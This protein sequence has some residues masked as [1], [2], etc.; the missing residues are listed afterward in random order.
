[1]KIKDSEESNKKIKIKKIKNNEE[2]DGT[3]MA[4]IRSLD[5]FGADS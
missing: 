5:S 3:D 1:M 4:D 2:F